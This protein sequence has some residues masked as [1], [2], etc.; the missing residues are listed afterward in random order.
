MAQELWR[1]WAFSC[2]FF[3]T[4]CLLGILLE[5]CLYM[6][7]SCYIPFNL[8]SCLIYIISNYWPL[9]IPMIGFFRSR[10]WL[11]AYMD[12]VN[13]IVPSKKMKYCPIMEKVLQCIITFLGLLTIAGMLYI[14]WLC[15]GCLLLNHFLLPYFRGFNCASIFVIQ[16]YSMM[17]SNKI[18][19]VF[20]FH[21]FAGRWVFT[22]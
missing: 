15:V 4:E 11:S 17:S 22:H 8:S 20:T 3:F 10:F 12:C 21:S 14:K 1:L 13:K 16:C 2:S 7:F 5:I 6:S 18:N 19:V 9:W